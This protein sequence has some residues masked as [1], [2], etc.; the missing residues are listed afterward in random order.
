MSRYL[1]RLNRYYRF[2]LFSLKGGA[3]GGGGGRPRLVTFSENVKRVNENWLT[4]M[5]RALLFVLP[6]EIKRF[7]VSVSV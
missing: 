5:P 2:Y 3:G 7:H 6:Q 1:T 4:K